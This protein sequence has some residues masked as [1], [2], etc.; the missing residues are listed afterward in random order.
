MNKNSVII[1]I[2]S[3]I[4]I[5]IF[6][7]AAY[8]LTSQQTPTDFPAANQILPTDHVKWS[9]DKKTILVEYS[10]LQCPAC[11]EFHDY[12][13]QFEASSSADYNLTHHITFVYRNYPLTQ[14]HPHAR[15]AA[16]AAE[17][18]A[19][20][21]KFFPFTD[22]LFA[23][24]TTWSQQ[25]DAVSYFISYAK[26]LGLNVDQFKSDMQ[27]KAVEDKV[28]NDIQSGNSVDIQ[29][30]PTFFLNGKKLDS[31]QSFDQFKQLLKNA[32]GL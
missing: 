1:G 2:L 10:D 9:P 12:I 22:K 11:K 26:D 14:I 16:L 3:V 6:L 15:E 19:I 23:T 32:A 31:I 30:T 28:N 25:T 4:G 21:G 20:Q 29:A 7:A 27:S 24:Q 8:I 18:A 13:Q 17:A 5:I